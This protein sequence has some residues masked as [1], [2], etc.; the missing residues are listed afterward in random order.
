[1]INWL[2]EQLEI[3]RGNNDT[4]YSMEGLRGL[5][6]FL[7]FLVHYSATMKP[8]V[9]GYSVTI[10]HY[11]HD[12]G[13]LGV[14]LFFVLSGYLIYGLIIKDRAWSLLDYTK[15][16]I[17][18]IYPTFLVVFAAYLILSFL[19]PSESKLPDSK[20]D[21]ITYI[22]QNLFLL[23]GIFNI[24]PIITVAWSLS[25]EVFYYV[26]IPTVILLTKMK[27]WSSRK[28]LKFWCIASILAFTLIPFHGHQVRLLMFVAGILLFE[29][30]SEKLFEIKHG[31]ILILL[32]ALTMFGLRTTIG[33]SFESAIAIV[34][35]LFLLLGLCAFHPNS[36]IYRW[37]TLTPVRWLGNMSYS[38]Y[39][40]HGLTL[41]FI[42]L[43]LGLL[44]SNDFVSTTIYYWLLLPSFALTL[45]T[46]FLLYWS[47][48]RPLSLTRKKV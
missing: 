23:P 36:N 16:R 14:D 8:W 24:K 13:R 4:I 9:D 31:G 38:Y 41:K 18:R 3:S 15:R 45:I 39:L 47:V 43:I 20:A 40:V 19:F 5:A 2:T 12:V 37:L 35:V 29:I 34:F 7:V 28:R 17:Q 25:Y 44:V 46:S 1:M 21:A 30:H 32:L 42:G 48:E 10:A 33:I 22:L 27:C 11:V 6:V 26:L